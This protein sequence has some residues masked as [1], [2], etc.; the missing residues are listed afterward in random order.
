MKVNSQ[1]GLKENKIYGVI[2]DIKTVYRAIA[3]KI[4]HEV[5]VVATSNITPYEVSKARKAHLMEVKRQQSYAFAE[6][7]RQSLRC[8]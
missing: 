7:H 6:A 4:Y 1:E 8:L 2:Y 3:K 5:S